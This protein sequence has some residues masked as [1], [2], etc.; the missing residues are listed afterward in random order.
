MAPVGWW[1]E[2]AEEGF[3]CGCVGEGTGGVWEGTCVCGER[4]R[5]SCGEAPRTCRRGR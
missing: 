2:R 3:G 5:G 1:V 4:V